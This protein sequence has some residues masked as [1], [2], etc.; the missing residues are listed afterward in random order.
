MET[1]SIQTARYCGIDVA[2]QDLHVYFEG[3]RFKV[4]N[5]PVGFETLLNQ[6]PEGMLVVEATGGYEDAF[7]SFCAQH[8]R[9]VCVINPTR[10][11]RYA[12]AKGLEAKT[13]PIDAE[14]IAEY[15]THFKPVPIQADYLQRKRLRELLSQRDDLIEMINAERCRMEMACHPQARQCIQETLE[16]MKK[17][18]AKIDQAVDSE[19]A[20]V[21]AQKERLCQI[22]GIGRVNA[23]TALAFLPELGA[24]TD[25]QAASLAGLAPYDHQSGKHKGHAFI[26]GGRGNLRVKLYMAA[27]CASRYNS[28]L[29]AFYQG[30]LAKGKPAKVALTAVMRKL[31]VLMNKLLRNPAFQLA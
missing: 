31:V 30:L 26:R 13:D 22:K 6:V 16:H 4:P 25:K 14:V 28:I 17:Q 1:Q 27:V 3:K 19:M 2:K 23:A 11:R 10:I 8:Q 20:T 12:Q 5:A 7:V 24:L 21:E 18:I 29:K 15:A 9:P